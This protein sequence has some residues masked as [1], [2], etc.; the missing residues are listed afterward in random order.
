MLMGEFVRECRLAREMT[1][2]ELAEKCNV[3]A[4]Q[5]IDLEMDRWS[6]PPKAFL[7]DLACELGISYPYLLELAGWLEDSKDTKMSCR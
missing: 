6:Q 1:V 5:L 4:V 2:C 3:R 7:R